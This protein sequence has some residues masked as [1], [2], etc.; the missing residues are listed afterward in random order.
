L[1]NSSGCL[2]PLLS[3]GYVAETPDVRIEHYLAEL[4][5]AFEELYPKS[6]FVSKFRRRRDPL[7]AG[8]MVAMIRAA[9]ETA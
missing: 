1:P 5:W 2:A 4:C 7:M 8:E 6:R 9:H 3:A